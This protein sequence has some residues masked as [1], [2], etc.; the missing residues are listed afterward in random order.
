MPDSARGS[1]VLKA[2]CHG[3]E[4]LVITTQQLSVSAVA[5]EEEIIGVNVR[6]HQAVRWWFSST[7][8]GVALNFFAETGVATSRLNHCFL[9]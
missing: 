6:L 7:L 8:S 1:Q 3:E 5:L 9:T 4:N 2:A